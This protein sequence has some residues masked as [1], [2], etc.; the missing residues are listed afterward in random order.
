MADGLNYDFEK[1]ENDS[2]VVAP[3]SGLFLGKFE[4]AALNHPLVPPAGLRN[5]ILAVNDLATGLS[6]AMPHQNLSVA[7]EGVLEYQKHALQ[8][9]LD[10]GA[11]F[12]LSSQKIDSIIGSAVAP[13][14]GAIAEIGLAASRASAMFE[15]GTLSREK[16]KAT[17]ELSSVFVDSIKGQ[18][19][20][21]VASM[22]RLNESGILDSIK[23]AT[24]SAR[25]VSSGFTTILESLPTYPSGIAIH[26][27]EVVQEAGKLDDDELSEHQEK[28]DAMLYKVDSSL[29]DFRKGC[30]KAFND[31]GPD[32]IGQASSSM[33]RLVDNLLR[34]LAPNEMVTKSKYFESSSEAKDAKG[35]PT[36][37]A[38]VFY[39]VDYDSK[40]AKHLERLAEGLLKAHES[41][42]AWDHNPLKKD[43][44]VGGAL[45]AIEGNLI[46]FLSESKVG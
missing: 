14:S 19:S 39:A 34:I 42:D 2:E 17:Q 8:S 22:E 21:M 33:R 24:T 44:F 38:R 35:R 10:V 1:S 43:D 45:I 16:L 31:K 3:Q 27:L 26:G 32:Y 13:M 37:K 41:L 6:V 30:W 36:R 5:S 15:G 46:S 20:I 12:S 9:V 25:M 28:L 23:A 29:V 40:Q 7:Y 18:Q 4:S 11:K